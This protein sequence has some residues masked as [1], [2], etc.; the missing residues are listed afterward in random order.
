MPRFSPQQLILLVLLGVFIL[1]LT[2]WRF[3]AMW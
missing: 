2:L 1:G 3:R